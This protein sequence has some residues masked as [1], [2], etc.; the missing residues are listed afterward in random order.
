MPRTN[1]VRR[2]ACA[3]S[4]RCR[5]LGDAELRLARLNQPARVRSLFEQRDSI[6]F[7]VERVGGEQAG[8]A[9]TDDGRLAPRRVERADHTQASDRME[10]ST[11]GNSGSP[12]KAR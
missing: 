7:L 4:P 10:R 12:L 8:D 6:T 3:A 11:R 5:R 2:Y 1:G 9:S